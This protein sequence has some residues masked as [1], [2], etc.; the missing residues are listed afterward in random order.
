MEGEQLES[1]ELCKNV[2][3]IVEPWNSSDDTSNFPKPGA[4]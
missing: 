1:I 4:H 3:G 2:T